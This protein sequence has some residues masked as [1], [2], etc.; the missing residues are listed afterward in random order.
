M[1]KLEKMIQWM[2][3][4]QGKVS[5][6]MT[7]RLG[8]NSYDCSS[9][10]Y[11]SLIAGGFLASGTMGNTDTLFSHLEKAGWTMVQA[12]STGNYPAKRGDI[13]IWGNRGASGGAAGHTGIFVDDL[14]SIIHCN[15]G[16]NGIT[17]NN[18]D[19]I[20][21]LNGCP[22]MTIYRYSQ[23]GSSQPIPAIPAPKPTPQQ[24]EGKLL[25]KS[26]TFYP[27]RRLAVSKDTDPDDVVSPALAYYLPGSPIHYDRYT[28]SNG[29]VWISYLDRGGNRRYIA[30]GPDDG[31]IDT[32]W[33]KGFFN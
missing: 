4:R 27:D 6:S 25:V 2:S 32:T 33:G 13:F 10:V 21:Y 23:G 1:T 18:H 8:P 19:T 17:V 24:G 28:H 12:D 14:D 31:R 9:A 29:Y 11:F 7:A 3:E 20:W 15:Y 5:Y 30:V 22:E 26:G 16:Y